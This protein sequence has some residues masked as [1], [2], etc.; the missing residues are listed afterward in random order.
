MGGKAKG[1]AAATKAD[2]EELAAAINKQFNRMDIQYGILLEQLRLLTDD[3]R[4]LRWSFHGVVQ[5]VSSHDK[6]ID[7]LKARVGLAD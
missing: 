1:A 7:K 3:M 5:L 4:D 6:E 2:V